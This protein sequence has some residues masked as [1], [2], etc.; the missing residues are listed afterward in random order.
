MSAGL[1]VGARPHLRALCAVSR[2][3][4]AL[5]ICPHIM[6]GACREILFQFAASDLRNW[7][8]Q[9]GEGGVGGVPASGCQTGDRG[10]PGRTA[11]P[12]AALDVPPKGP[13]GG[14]ISDPFR[15]QGK[16]R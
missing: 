2:F 8:R 13:G 11:A 10:W 6:A 3:C 16:C 9:P 4:R 7:L 14:P 5:V 12:A 1:I 15:A